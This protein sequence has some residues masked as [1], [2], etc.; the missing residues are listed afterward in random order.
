M[1]IL[2]GLGALLILLPWLVRNYIVYGSPVFVTT[3]GPELLW[4]GNNPRATGFA[5]TS[6]GQTMLE[7]A[8]DAFRAQLLAADEL[9]QQQFFW[10]EFLRF[11]TNHPWRVLNLFVKKF[12]YFWWF[13]PQS[14]REHPPWA[15]LLYRPVY[16]C[17][18]LAAMWGFIVGFHRDNRHEFILLLLFLVII[19]LGQSLFFVEGRHR[20]A[21]MPALLVPGTV[22]ILDV[23]IRARNVFRTGEEA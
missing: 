12:Y 6:S 3:A 10:N 11:V 1:V 9:T 8:P 23:V 16:A 17:A 14:G 22:G 18:L 5:V 20:L 15:L 4:I 7:A 21:L 19:S 2:F 13:S